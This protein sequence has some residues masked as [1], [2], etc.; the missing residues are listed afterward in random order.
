MRQF[1]PAIFSGTDRYH[2]AARVV[3]DQQYVRAAFA[4]ADRNGAVGGRDCGRFAQPYGACDSTVEFAITVAA[5]HGRTGLG[6]VLMTAL[7]EAARRRGLYEMEGFVLAVN[8]PMLRLAAG[9]G[10][11][12]S[13]DPDDFSVRLCRLRLAAS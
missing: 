12:I 2:L 1:P 13:N 10:F 6:R 8:Q 3:M 11:T 7:I 4:S 5:D 9:L